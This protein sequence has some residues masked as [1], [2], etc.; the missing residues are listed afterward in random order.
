MNPKS[1]TMIDI[2]KLESSCGSAVCAYR[3]KGVCRSTVKDYCPMYTVYRPE[4]FVEKEFQK[5]TPPCSMKDVHPA[6][7]KLLDDLRREAGIPIVLLCV[8]RSRQHDLD[9]GR[10]GNS[11][12]T[13]G[14]GVDIL[15]RTTANRFKIVAASIKLGV[16]RIGIGTT[17]IH[18]DIG[19]SDILPSNV[20]WV[21]DSNGKAL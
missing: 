10:S 11:A 20:L 17:F 6:L 16:D 18:I 9:H 21:Y 3:G 5:C 8:Y 13:L 4:F 19:D 7:L 2:N 1:R 12:H 15:C 14:L